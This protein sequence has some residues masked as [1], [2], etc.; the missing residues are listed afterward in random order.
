MKSQ[1]ILHDILVSPVV[2]PFQSSSYCSLVSA[3]LVDLQQA[4]QYFTFQSINLAGRQLAT[5]HLTLCLAVS[6]GWDV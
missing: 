4:N 3:L 5:V 6:L 1:N 2:V